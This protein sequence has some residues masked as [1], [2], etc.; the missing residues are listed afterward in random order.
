MPDPVG[1]QFREKLPGA[2]VI[3]MLDAAP[4]VGCYDVEFLR[5]DFQKPG[6]KRTS[7]AFQ[8]AKNAHLIGKAFVGFRAPK[9]LV[10]PAI[11]ADADLRPQS[12]LDV[13]H[14]WGNMAHEEVQASFEAK[15][16]KCAERSPEELRDGYQ[17]LRCKRGGSARVFNIILL[18]GGIIPAV[19]SDTPARGTRMKEIN[20]MR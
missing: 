5:M 16:P 18:E 11:V 15:V 20:S 1:L 13:V 17:R 19:V 6:H 2:F 14:A 12:V 7:A 9:R 3:E 8:V 4:A 10:H